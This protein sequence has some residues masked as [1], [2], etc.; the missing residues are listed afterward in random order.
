M[1]SIKDLKVGQL[2]TNCYLLSDN[3]NNTIIIDPG[4]SADY[5]E[6]IISDC[7][8]TPK[9]IIATHGHF[10]HIMGAFEI[11]EAY[12]IPFFIKKEDDFLVKGMK[13]S[14]AYFLGINKGIYPPRNIKY[15][16]NKVSF[17][18]LDIEVIH[19]PGHTPGSVLLNLKSE[20]KA[21]CGD[22]IFKNNCV[23]RYDFSYSSLSDLKKSVKKV[24]SLPLETDIYP[25]HYEKFILSDIKDYLGHFI[26]K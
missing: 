13:N 17:G 12:N 24:L 26:Q 7:E 10:D 3:K 21:F 25:G 2:D 6:N 8:L 1:V 22:L 4:D 11:Q 14:A 20:K 5:I 15:L 9:M 16:K 19:T 18:C 23:G